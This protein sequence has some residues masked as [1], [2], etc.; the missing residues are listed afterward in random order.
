[1]STSG[2]QY[3]LRIG[4]SIILPNSLGSVS[5][6]SILSLK[7]MLTHSSNDTSSSLMFSS[8]LCFISD[9]TSESISISTGTTSR[10]S[11]KSNFECFS[12]FIRLAKFRYVVLFS[13][14]NFLFYLYHYLLLTFL[15]ITTSFPHS[16]VYTCISC[17]YQYYQKSMT[18]HVVSSGA[19]QR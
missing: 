13:L 3:P 10:F 7:Q 9:Y 12:F 5:I 16:Y 2:K 15:L 1:M 11:P 17:V 6:C 19:L 8:I 18:F 14:Y 4:V